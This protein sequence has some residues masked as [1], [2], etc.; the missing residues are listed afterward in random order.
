M[1]NRHLLMCRPTHFRITYSINP[2]M[3]PDGAQPNPAT[4]T[5][6]YDALIAAH[7]AAGRT[8]EFIGPQP[9]LPDMTFTANHALIRGQRAILGHLPPERAAEVAHTQR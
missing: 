2:Y 1:Y 6:E 4:L 8:V 7:R 9:N 3:R 5:R